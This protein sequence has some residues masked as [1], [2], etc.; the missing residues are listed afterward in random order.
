M[1]ATKNLAT[2]FH[3]YPRII[4]LCP[5]LA[6]VLKTIYQ[7][8]KWPLKF[9]SI[10]SVFYQCSSVAKNKAAPVHA[11]QPSAFYLTPHSFF[12]SSRCACCMNFKRRKSAGVV[13]MLRIQISAI[14]SGFSSILPFLPFSPF[15]SNLISSGSRFGSPCSLSSLHSVFFR[16]R[17]QLAVDWQPFQGN[18]ILVLFFLL[19]SFSYDFN[20]RQDPTSV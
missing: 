2:D 1:A 6:S 13:W 16:S 19:K 9:H 8:K 15:S 7:S 18:R 20:A 17:R 12:F 5:Y 4:E 3:G 11:K 10:K 14:C